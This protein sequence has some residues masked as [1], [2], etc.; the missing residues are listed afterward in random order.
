MHAADYISPGLTKLMI[1]RGTRA[2]FMKDKKGWLPAHV[3]ASRHVSPEKLRMLLEVNPSALYEKTNNGE[4]LLDLAKTTATKSHPN[5]ALIEELNRHLNAAFH[6]H[7]PG[8]MEPHP[9]AAAPTSHIVL[10][11]AFAS[12]STPAVL[13]EE[14]DGSTRGRLDSADSA[15][16]WAEH[17]G[18]N[19]HPIK[20][21]VGTASQG[22]MPGTSRK[23]KLNENNATEA[24][25]LLKGDKHFQDYLDEEE[26][27]EGNEGRPMQI[28]RV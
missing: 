25:L 28:A 21:E 8:P 6:A 22:K 14:S 13:S 16:A 7:A 1:E 17:W 27:E 20:Q 5:Y 4:T 26:D 11:P 12:P 3:A 19:D 10:P 15:K 23:R 24:L 18:Q 2:C 9:Y